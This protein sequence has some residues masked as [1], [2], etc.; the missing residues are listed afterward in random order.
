ML[1]LDFFF[2]QFLSILEKIGRM[3]DAAG[4][5]GVNV[6][7]LQEAWSKSILVEF[8]GQKLRILIVKKY[9]SCACCLDFS[10]ESF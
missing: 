1:T 3:I 4:A 2:L 6:I 10:I 7:C 9:L 8:D 5:M